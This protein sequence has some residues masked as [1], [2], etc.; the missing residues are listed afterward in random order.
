MH[1]ETASVPFTT[2]GKAVLPGV[3]NNPPAKA[4]GDPNKRDVTVFKGLNDKNTYQAEPVN[5]EQAR[6]EGIDREYS[7]LSGGVQYPKKKAAQP[8]YEMH[9]GNLTHWDKGESNQGVSNK[10]R[11][12][13]GHHDIFG[14]RS[15][16]VDYN[17]GP[18]ECKS[19]RHNIDLKGSNF[20]NWA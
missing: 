18:T 20:M 16:S 19:I 3:E 14:H 17:R 6:I 15:S 11:T 5:Y 1:E 9:N 10:I 2:L 8:S 13:H 4:A 12:E 7:T